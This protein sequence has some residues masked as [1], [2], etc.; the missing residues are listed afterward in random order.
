MGSRERI[1]LHDDNKIVVAVIVKTKTRDKN[2]RKNKVWSEETASLD[3]NENR[4]KIGNDE[5]RGEKKKDAVHI[6]RWREN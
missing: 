3:I 5:R 2:N 1:E 6:F 4:K